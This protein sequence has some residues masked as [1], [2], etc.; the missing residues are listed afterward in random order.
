MCTAAYST[1]QTDAAINAVER[2]IA[3]DVGIT[4]WWQEQGTSMQH[5]H[6]TPLEHLRLCVARGSEV[7][8]VYLV[9]Q[10]PYLV[11]RI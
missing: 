1:A 5:T 7:P 6:V 3:N 4:P 9:A 2:W 10:S 8:W 11:S